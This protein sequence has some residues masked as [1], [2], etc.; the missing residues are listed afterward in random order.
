MLRFLAPALDPLSFEP[1]EP[2][3]LE[4]LSFEPFDRLPSF[5]LS[6]LDSELECL[7]PSLELDRFPC[8]PSLTSLIKL[9][10]YFPFMSPSK[11][12]GVT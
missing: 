11:S 1:F 2:A 6:R 4:T 12:I 9:D 7:P 3:R 8:K 5:E 10:L